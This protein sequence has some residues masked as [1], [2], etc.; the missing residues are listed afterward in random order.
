M[1]ENTKKF[2]RCVVYGN[3]ALFGCLKGKVH[4]FID[5]TF[6]CTPHPFYQTLI[7]MVFDENTEVYVPILF[8]LM[9]CKSG[10][11]YWNALHL[12]KVAIGCKLDPLTVTCDFE[13]ALIKG[14]EDQFQDARIVG[15][16][17]HWKQAIRR[18]MVKLGIETEHIGRA[19]S[20]NVLDILTIIPVAEIV[21]KGIPYCKDVLQNEIEADVSKWNKFW[22]YF[23]TYWC[24]SETFMST[25]NVHSNTTESYDLRNR[26]NNALEKY[27]RRINGF[28]PY[29]HPSLALFVTKIEEETRYQIKRLDDIR[30]GRVVPD[31]PNEA[32]INAIN[33]VYT[34]FQ[35][36]TSDV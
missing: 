16:L 36:P 10:W 1:D 28:Y 35:V 21:P 30:Y 11:A 15:C 22:N 8:I 32:I 34:N 26:T 18:K 6:R 7:I 33:P 13:S 9:T 2:E 27:N 3:P 29:P 25:W 23:M 19:M 17:F 20:K 31:E 24:S 14:V 4:L 12:A 5:A